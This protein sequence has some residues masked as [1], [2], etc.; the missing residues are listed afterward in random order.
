VWLVVTKEYSLV[1][2]STI[3]Y[4]DYFHGEHKPSQNTRVQFYGPYT[5]FDTLVGDSIMPDSYF[6]A[7]IIVRKY[8]NLG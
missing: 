6:L 7:I 5:C 4:V 1:V 3:V 2:Q 8:I